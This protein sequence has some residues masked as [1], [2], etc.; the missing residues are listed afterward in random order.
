MGSI[1][2][3]KLNLT[4]KVK[5]NHPLTPPPPPAP[6]H[7][8]PTSTT[9]PTSTKKTMGILT[10]VRYTYGPNVVFLAWRVMNYRAD[11][12]SDG[13]TDWW[14]DGRMQA[15]TIPKGQYWPWVKNWHARLQQRL[16]L[17]CDQLQFYESSSTRLKHA[18]WHLCRSTHYCS[19]RGDWHYDCTPNSPTSQWETYV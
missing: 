14:M 1:L 9:T 11:R 19:N 5:V 2:T 17:I 8:H 18:C 16:V 13:R 10:K 7:H 3:L 6:S 15:T 12:L 4:L